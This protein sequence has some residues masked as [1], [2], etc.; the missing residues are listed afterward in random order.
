MQYLAAAV[1]VACFLALWVGI[2]ALSRKR[3]LGNHNKSSSACPG[4]GCGGIERCERKDED[5]QGK[6][7]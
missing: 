7:T 6:K 2:D 3:G 1:V 4:C 5:S